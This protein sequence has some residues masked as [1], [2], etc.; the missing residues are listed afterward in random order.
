MTKTALRFASLAVIAWA[1]QATPSRAETVRHEETVTETSDGATVKR[2]VTEKTTQDA[3]V[4]TRTET[5]WHAEEHLISG[6]GDHKYTLSD[7]D[8]NKDGTL[9][10]GEVA[11]MLFKVYDVDGNGVIDS[12]EYERPTRVLVSPMEKETVYSYDFD[13]DG[14]ADA[15]QRTYESFMKDSRLDLFDR[16][17]K[18][19]TAHEFTDKHFMTVDVNR[20]H[21]I[22][23]DE[24]RGTYIAGV[25]RKNKEKARLNK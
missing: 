5:R 25:D 12:Q 13:G 19:L 16:R 6:R 20:D 18:G 21:A 10:F 1:L 15:T 23:M 11:R 2:T 14:V 22:D 4:S 24:W 17:T 7:F 8:R 9:S 3:P